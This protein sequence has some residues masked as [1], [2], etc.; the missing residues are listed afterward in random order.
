MDDELLGGMW[1]AVVD[2]ERRRD[3]PRTDRGSSVVVRADGSVAL[4]DFDGA[5]LASDDGDLRA[6]QARLLVVTALAV[7][8]DRAL[9]AAVAAIGP[10]GPGRRAALPAA[11]SARAAGPVPRCAERP[12][13]STSCARRPSRPPGSRSRRWSACGG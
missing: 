9:S 4:A 10:D 3:R 7:G 6:D 2:A 12:G 8:P 11:G 13:R 5:A 1:R